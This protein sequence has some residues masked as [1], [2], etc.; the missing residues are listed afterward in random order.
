MAV[1]LVEQASWVI[2][3]DQASA[4]HVYLR[5]CDVAFSD[6]GFVY[7]GPKFD[8]DA[9]IRLPGRGR[10]LMPGFVN[11]H[12]HP[13]SEP[14]RR[15][16]TDEITSP[17]FHHSSLYEFLPVL[18]GDDEARA[19]CIKVALWELLKSGVTTLVDL[20]LPYDGWLDALADSGIRACVAPMY[21]D[22][23][24]HTRDGHSLE[25]AWDAARGRENFENAARLVERA[26]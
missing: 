13:T 9:T 22:A 20:S 14:L 3:W 25:Y 5:D 18:E 2:A 24:W 26:R 16:I 4:T 15:G 6:E 17:G 12:S 8:R 10:M 19:A 1:T 21:R 7:V 11:I 23:R